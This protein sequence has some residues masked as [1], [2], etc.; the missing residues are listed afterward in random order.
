MLETYVM[1]HQFPEA[2]DASFIVKTGPRFGQ[3]VVTASTVVRLKC[4]FR[5]TNSLQNYTKIIAKQDVRSFTFTHDLA[6]GTLHVV[7]SNNKEI[8][9]RELLHCICMDYR[10]GKL[11]EYWAT[12]ASRCLQYA[13]VDT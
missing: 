2:V 12:Y 5:F 13:C 11:Y 6:I 8:L 1:I 4:T 9:P 10:K 7:L 3:T